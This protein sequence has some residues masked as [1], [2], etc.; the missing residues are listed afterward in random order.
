MT[1]PVYNH[2]RSVCG[3][4][5]FNV[6]QTEKGQL[7]SLE[8]LQDSSAGCEIERAWHLATWPT[9]ITWH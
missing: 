3:C 9:N 5:W 2:M 1:F 7:F 8:V 4:E 6:I